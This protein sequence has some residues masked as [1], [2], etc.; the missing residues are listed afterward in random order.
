ME[1]KQGDVLQVADVS[2]ANVVTLYLLPEVNL[3][4]KPILKRTL[5]PGSRVV[6]HDFDMGDDWKPEKT[7][8]V[9]AD[10]FEHTI[11]LWTIPEKK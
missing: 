8:T 11:Y 4:L 1:F 5:K 6:S 2:A 3:R 10:G 9:K 7:I